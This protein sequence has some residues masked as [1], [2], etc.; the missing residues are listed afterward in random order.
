ML[1]SFF[2]NIR[3]HIGHF[4][5]AR[6]V[7]LKKKI[8]LWLQRFVQIIMDQEVLQQSIVDYQLSKRIFIRIRWERWRDVPWYVLG[9]FHVISFSPCLSVMLHS[10]KK[11]IQHRLH[12]IRVI[13]NR[14]Q[15]RLMY[16]PVGPLIHGR[17]SGFLLL[18][19][20]IHV[21][22]SHLSISTVVSFFICMPYKIICSYPDLNTSNTNQIL[23]DKSENNEPYMYN[24]R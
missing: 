22:I 9:I 5:V 7:I 14:L 3:K 4:L 19:V 8:Q 12:P 17:M 11:L 1:N 2:R 18:L 21:V 16:H 24:N 6:K 23:S 20:C 10:M 15:L 13:I